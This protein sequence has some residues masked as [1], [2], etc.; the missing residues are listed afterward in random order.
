MGS[1]AHVGR[2]LYRWLSAGFSLLVVVGAVVGCSGAS[3][4]APGS[5]SARCS[6]SISQAKSLTEPSP[7][8]IAVAGSPVAALATADGRWAFVSLHAQSGGALEVLHLTGD[9]ARAVRTVRLPGQV[10]AWGMA[11]THDR[12][13]LLVAGGDG[14]AVVSVSALERG[15]RRPVLGTL[16]D[17]SSGQFEVALSP[18]DRYAFVS[19]ELTG[20]VS[21]FDLARALHGGFSVPGV[22]SPPGVAVGIVHLAP[23]P[24]GVAVSPDGRLLY[25]TTEGGYGQHG[26][27]WIIDTA[28]AERGDIGHA[29][30]AN[31]PAG[32]QPV[33]VALAPN[34]S[35]VWVT[36][37][38][39]NALLAFNAKS[40]QA[41]P[42]S[43]LQAV[44]PVGSEPVG[45]AL[46]D[47]G[48][49]ALVANSNRGIVP[50]TRSDRAQTIT[51]V[52]TY[53][54]LAHR[55][56]V[57]GEIRAGLYPRDLNVNPVT[58]QVLVANFNSNTV[59]VFRQPPQP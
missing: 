11:M 10:T 46:V 47:Q 55:P 58:G 41:H 20:A 3:R 31:A 30:L 26:R 50:G 28:R 21:V 42:A 36:A 8:F 38:Q 52:N 7:R 9:T 40:L 56:A 16:S 13:L 23:D 2:V 32:C 6:T 5:L 45:L 15:G 49:V 14:T 27:L 53:A 54:A 48:H 4:R 25:V 24:V 44:V 35:E 1:M 18:D 59:E 51:V 34:G 39:S 43:A 29:V 37:L 33:R 22:I 12:R 57:I 19:D 17:S